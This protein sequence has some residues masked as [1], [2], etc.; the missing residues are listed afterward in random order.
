[1]TNRRIP[2]GAWLVAGLTGLSILSSACGLL[3]Q[4]RSPTHSPDAFD[5]VRNIDLQPQFPQAGEE[6]RPRANGAKPYN[7]FG[8]DETPATPPEQPAADGAQPAANGEGYNLNFENAPVVTVAKVI[9]GDILGVGYT[10]DPRIQG[11]VTVS[12]GRPI[13]K[14]DLL[15]ALENA[16]RSSNIVLVPDNAS[17][18]LIPAGDAVGTGHVNA[19]GTTPDQGYGISIVPLKYVSAQTILKLLDS[20]AIKPNMARVEPGRN[21]IVVQGSGPERRTALETILSFDVDWMRS[22]SV[23]IYPLQNASPEAM[24]AELEKIMES[25]E[26]GLNQTLIKFQPIA[27]LNAVLVVTRKANLLRAASKTIA[28]LD[29]ANTNSGVQVYRVRYGDARQMALILNDLFGG[30][31]NTGT[32]VDSSANQIA[33]GAGITTTTTGITTTTS[34]AQAQGTS[35]LDQ[36]S[37]QTSMSPTGSGA[38]GM[39]STGTGGLATGQSAPGSSGATLGTGRG[40]GVNALGNR[41]PTSVILPGIRITAD[42]A[43]NSLL[44]FANQ[45]NYRLIEQTLQKLDRPQLQVAIHATIAEITLNDGLQYGVQYFL[46]SKN[47][48]LKNDTGSVGLDSTNTASAASTAASAVINRVLPGFN[49]LVGAASDPSVIIDALRNITDVKVLSTPSVVVID[50][51]VATLQ[52]GDQV[53]ITTQSA[54]NLNNPNTSIVSSIDYRNTGVILRVLPRINVNGNVVLDIEQEISNVSD[55]VTANTL[56]PTVSQRKVKSSIAVAS[57]QTVLLG[58]LISERQ[59]RGRQGIPILSE[60]PYLGEAFSH[61]TRGVS[62][63]ELMVFIQPQIIRDSVDAYK[64]AEE[65]RGKLRGSK[66]SAFPV[67]PALR[68]DPLFVR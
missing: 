64:I 54:T 40:S 14:G 56:T 57:G 35:I 49:L 16:L 39:T 60:I 5:V 67:G 20:L 1:V 47:L 66:E 61:N 46:K 23:G 59:S 51:Q 42:V 58:G 6:S 32:G 33:P 27:R 9:L 26:G 36:S 22:Q 19:G 17:Y 15:F 63:T 55:T 29:M 31:S 10:I 34:G 2:N 45:E 25:G 18:R 24:I 43:N 21:L 41:A 8:R 3:D 38:T 48:G 13:G 12:S 44:I 7:F 28:R 37:R 53:P 30:R 11:T 65:L 4:G 50:N 62:R 52:V 68:T